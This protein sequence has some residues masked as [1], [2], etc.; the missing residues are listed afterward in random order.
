MKTSRRISKIQTRNSKSLKAYVQSSSSN[1]N[2]KCRKR[3]HLQS[4]KVQADPTLY[5]TRGSIKA[6]KGWALLEEEEA[7]VTITS[8]P[9]TTTGAGTRTI[10]MAI[11]GSSSITTGSTITSPTME[12]CTT[13]HGT[14]RVVV[15]AAGDTSRSGPHTTIKVASSSSSMVVVVVVVVVAVEAVVAALI[16]RLLSKV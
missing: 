10:T 15:M 14:I 3:T 8:R 1:N 6:T 13:I 4:S 16:H 12:G 5:L 7:M 2:S 9:C 11:K